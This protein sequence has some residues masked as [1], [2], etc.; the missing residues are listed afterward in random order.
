[1][2]SDVWSLGVTLVEALTQYP[3]VWD[4]STQT[5]P[6]VPES[7]PQ[8]FADIARECLRRE[9]AR[10]CTLGE[11]KARLDPAQPI[12]KPAG[13]AP[14]SETGQAAPAKRRW[15]AL[16]AAAP[17]LIAVVAAMQ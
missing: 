1:T 16:I 17:V 3:P 15:P 2:A 14:A 7:I 6:V 9:P 8:P 11:I 4:R 5:E 12:A 10:R 13:K